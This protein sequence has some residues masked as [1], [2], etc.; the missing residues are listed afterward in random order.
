MTSTS[1]AS[2]SSPQEAIHGRHITQN[3]ERHRGQPTATD[4]SPHVL[5]SAGPPAP[6]SSESP[7]LP[8]RNRRN[9]ASARPLRRSS[10]IS[11]ARCHAAPVRFGGGGSHHNGHAAAEV[12]GGRVV[13]ALEGGYDLAALAASARAHVEELMKA[14]T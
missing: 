13:S 2:A 1:G 4:P 3:T 11:M 8:R 6:E 9:P 12:C 14:A 7:V 10:L 5:A